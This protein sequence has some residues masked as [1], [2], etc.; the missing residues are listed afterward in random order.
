MIYVALRQERSETAE[1]L[2]VMAS[3]VAASVLCRKVAH[4]RGEWPVEREAVQPDGED[5]AHVAERWQPQAGTAC[6]LYEVWAVPVTQED[7]IPGALP[8]PE[9]YP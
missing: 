5:E 3:D 7:L 6:G 9:P 1:V 8:D 2:G 4:R